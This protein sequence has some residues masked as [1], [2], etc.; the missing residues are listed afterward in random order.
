M[1]IQMAW[2]SHLWICKLDPKAIRA[3]PASYIVIYRQIS[4]MM[5]TSMAIPALTP[6]RCFHLD[7]IR[8][9]EQIDES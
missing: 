3:P 6:G 9:H 1:E 7:S 5:L 2:F 4:Q 8:I